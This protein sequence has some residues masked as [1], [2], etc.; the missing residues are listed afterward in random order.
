MSLAF[1]CLEELVRQRHL[2]FELAC[3]STREIIR[4]GEYDEGVQLTSQVAESRELEVTSERNH[5]V[6]RLVPAFVGRYLVV[7]FEACASEA[8]VLLEYAQV[9]ILVQV[10]PDSIVNPDW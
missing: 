3:E 9:Q 7:K 1:Y 10:R 2:D 4:V 8:E 6:R 5:V